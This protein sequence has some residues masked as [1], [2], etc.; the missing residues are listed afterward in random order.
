MNIV[1][2]TG[3]LHSFEH[4]FTWIYVYTFSVT[5]YVSPSVELGMPVLQGPRCGLQYVPNSK[6]QKS[7]YNIRISP[8]WQQLQRL[9]VCISKKQKQN[10]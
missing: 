8:L 7:W 10:T 1:L 3:L 4:V 2:Y 6:K 5:I 9:K